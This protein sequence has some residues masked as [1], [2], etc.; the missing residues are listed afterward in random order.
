[1][2]RTTCTWLGVA[3]AAA[4][5]L[6]LG[7]TSMAQAQGLEE[8]VVTARKREELLQ[9][10]PLAI[11]TFTTYHLTKPVARDMRHISS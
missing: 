2:V 10:V 3:A 6:D 7:A 1:M 8:I 4:F 11:T 5:I 9:T